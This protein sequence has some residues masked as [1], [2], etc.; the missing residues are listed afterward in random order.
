[1]DYGVSSIPL[2]NGDYAIFGKWTKL[3]GKVLITY[4]FESRL[5]LLRSFSVLEP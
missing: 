3:H 5:L 2:G 4:V 1:M